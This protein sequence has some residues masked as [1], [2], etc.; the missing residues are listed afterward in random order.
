MTSGDSVR[1]RQP[2]L[3]SSSAFCEPTVELM[4]RVRRV[5]AVASLATVM[6]ADE[7]DRGGGMRHAEE[8]GCFRGLVGRCAVGVAEPSANAAATGLLVAD[9]RGT[10]VAEQCCKH[11]LFSMAQHGPKILVGSGVCRCSS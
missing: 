2:R 1:R 8:D 5:R 9:Q 6:E 4:G 7:W 11:Q 10:E 3:L